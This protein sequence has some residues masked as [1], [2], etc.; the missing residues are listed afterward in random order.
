VGT[1][2]SKHARVRASIIDAALA[3]FADRPF[4]A[5]SVDE[6]AAAA[7]IGRRTFFRY[8]PTKED[9]VLDPRRLDREYAIDALAHRRDGED[10]IALVM[11]VMAELQRRAFDEV[12]QRHQPAVHRLSHDEPE[13]MARSWLLVERARTLIVEGLLGPTPAPDRL[14]RARVLVGA[15]LMA[16]DAAITGWNE[17]GR[18]EPLPAVLAR[19]EQDLRSALTAPGS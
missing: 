17:A 11:R 19:A 5:V 1:R 16:V 2:Q 13:V 15:C 4:S 8:F 18:I 7:G 3:L 9:V 12:H 6:I 14:L 10:D